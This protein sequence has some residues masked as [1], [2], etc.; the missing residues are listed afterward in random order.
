MR[1]EE[2]S[3]YKRLY[4]IG[5]G[6]DLHY[7]LKTSLEDFGFF[8]RSQDEN[9]ANDL[10]TLF[11][12]GFWGEFEEALRWLS[13]DDL[14]DDLFGLFAGVDK[15][16]NAFDERAATAWS[17]Q[18]EAVQEVL[19]WEKIKTLFEDWINQVYVPT[20]ESDGVIVDDEQTCYL[21]F[22]Y[23]DT[24]EKAFGVDAE[25]V[26]H[27]HG[28]AGGEIVVGHAPTAIDER[29]V[30]CVNYPEEREI[31]NCRRAFLGESE[32]HVGGIIARHEGFFREL[33]DVEEVVVAGFGFW[34]VDK[35]YVTR[36]DAALPA[37]ARWR[38]Y[39]FSKGDKDR[40][41]ESIPES[42]CSSFSEWPEN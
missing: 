29:D 10:E 27:I 39:H 17:Y 33:S 20:L 28:R 14:F 38:I 23:T 36:I 8:V 42:R 32:K 6:F 4:V 7:G 2:D 21:T 12:R 22:N 41:Q 31:E 15:G 37:R 3:L 40:A 25:R 35:P 26:L 24:L 16:G 34:D 19:D 18:C 9:L 13:P 30:G 11:Q 5:N 1:R